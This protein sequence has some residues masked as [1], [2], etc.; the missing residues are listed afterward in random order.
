MQ[1]RIIS[2]RERDEDIEDEVEMYA[3]YVPDPDVQERRAKTQSRAEA[4]EADQRATYIVNFQGA[5]QEVG[6]GSGSGVVLLQM[7]EVA[8]VVRDVEVATMVREEEVVT[9]VREEEVVITQ[10]PAGCLPSP[11]EA[12][13]NSFGCSLHQHLLS[14]LQTNVL[15]RDYILNLMKQVNTGDVSAS[16]NRIT[17]GAGTPTP[18]SSNTTE[19]SMVGRFV[20]SKAAVQQGW[21]GGRAA[22][23]WRGGRAARAAA[24][25]KQQQRR[26]QAAAARRGGAIGGGCKGA[27]SGYPTQGSRRPLLPC[28]PERRLLLVRG[29]ELAHEREKELL[30]EITDLQ[31][32]LVCA[33]DEIQR[34]K[35]R[36]S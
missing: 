28:K 16:A 6:S 15:Q 30:Q 35:T 17:D 2:R 8:T 19:K 27:G 33:Q 22:K 24:A 25:C 5:Q 31:W 12:M 10:I 13:S 32:R 36:K 20:C 14:I 11:S 3:K 34:L 9:V 26:E 7:V 4:C 1:E 18:I 29:L 21:R 23:R